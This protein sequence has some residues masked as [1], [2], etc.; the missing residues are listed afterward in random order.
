MNDDLVPVLLMFLI[1]LSLTSLILSLWWWYWNTEVTF[2]MW[3]EYV[4][5]HCRCHSMMLLVLAVVIRDLRNHQQCNSWRLLILITLA[6]NWWFGNAK[7]TNIISWRIKGKNV[8]AVFKVHRRVWH[9]I[10]L[11]NTWPWKERE[12]S[13]DT[14]E[15][16]AAMY[17]ETKKSKQITLWLKCKPRPKKR[18]ASDSSEVPQSKRHASL[19]NMRSYV[20]SIVMKLKEKHGDKYTP[21]Q[22]NC[23]AHMIHTHKHE[24]MEEP[25]NKSF[26]GK[27]KPSDATS[28]GSCVSPAKRISLRWV[29]Q[30]TW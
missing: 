26:F 14:H 3:L 11:H 25:P 5:T 1:P 23:W 12:A 4:C 22:L 8:W 30:S 16:L 10:W 24:S 2:Q 19:L 20:D 7:T 17:E 9:W 21:V 27:K 6:V 13:V 29:H 28:A 18:V 15:K